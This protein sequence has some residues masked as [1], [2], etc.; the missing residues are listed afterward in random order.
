[1]DLPDLRAQL[2]AGQE[3]L[4]AASDSVRIKGE[5]PGMFLVASKGNRSV[6][7]YSGDD[8]G[9]TIDPALDGELLGEL[10]YDSYDS[11]IAAALRWLDGCNLDQLKAT[12]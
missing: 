7:L 2:E 5:G 12:P 4:A 11:A 9:A 1:M 10:D 3:Q 8:A 6:E